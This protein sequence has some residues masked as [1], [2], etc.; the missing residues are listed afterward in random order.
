M[1]NLRKAVFLDRDGVINKERRDYVKTINEL[2]MIPDV[3]KAIKK[4]KGA[5]FLVVVVTNQSAVNR[6]LTNHDNINKIHSTIQNHLRKSNAS[7]D[8]FY[9]CPHRPDEN[10]ECR[11]PK[12]GLILKASQE[13]R[14]DLKSSWMVGDNDSDIEAAKSV[15][16]KTVKVDTKHGLIEAVEE[17]LEMINN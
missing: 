10:C 9:Y 5:G 16:C 12:P 14:I 4:L 8:G 3:G 6:G 15:G 7:L 2:E 13:L 1:N 11:K 17:I